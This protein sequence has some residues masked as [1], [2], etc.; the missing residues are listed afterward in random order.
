MENIKLELDSKN[1]GQFIITAE[2]EKLG[3]MDIL[4][5]GGTLT[6]FHTEVL[7][8]VEGK[9][10]AKKLFESMVNYARKNNLK[11]VALCPFIFAQFKRNPQQY[12]DIWTFTGLN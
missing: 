8:K 3:E 1:I 6:V 11:V 2:G 5:S 9:G 7:P 12:I 4:I 10:L